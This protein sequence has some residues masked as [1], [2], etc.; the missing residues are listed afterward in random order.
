MYAD[1]GNTEGK[2]KSEG[3]EGRQVPFPKPKCRAYG[4]NWKVYIWKAFI[5]SLIFC[6]ISILRIPIW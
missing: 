4:K 6:P 1:W 5:S 2:K 3:N